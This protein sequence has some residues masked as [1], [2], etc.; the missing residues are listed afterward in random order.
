M[1]EGEGRIHSDIYNAACV[2]KAAVTFS[3]GAVLIGGPRFLFFLGNH[4][5]TG[6][7]VR[8]AAFGSQVFFY[9]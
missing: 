7:L 3:V 6:S 4:Q 5:F 8:T 1:G 2:W 9:S